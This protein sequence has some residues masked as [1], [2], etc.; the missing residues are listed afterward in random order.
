MPVLDFQIVSILAGPVD[1]LPQ[2][3]TSEMPNHEDTELMY[4]IKETVT[5]RWKGLAAMVREQDRGTV[6]ALIFSSS[7]VLVSL[8]PPL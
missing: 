5:Q 4:H 7:S 1:L 8:L 2:S 3:S 6:L